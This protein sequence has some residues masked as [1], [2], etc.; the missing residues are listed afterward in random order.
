M[1]TPFVATPA[2]TLGACVTGNL[3][4]ELCNAFGEPLPGFRFS[5]SIPVTGDS[6]SH[7]LRWKGGSSAD[8]EFD[9][10]SLRLEWTERIVYAVG[11]RC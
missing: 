9:A 4:A 8:Y 11:N 1:K 2:L 5:D 6:I 3:R 7:S 10:V